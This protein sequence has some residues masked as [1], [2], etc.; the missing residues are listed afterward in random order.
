MRIKKNI[1]GISIVFLS[2]ILG[3]SISHGQEYN[4]NE[5]ELSL[6]DLL[7]IAS[8]SLGYF[9]LLIF[10]LFIYFIPSY[11]A[12]KKNHE[13]RWIIFVFNLIGGFTGILWLAAL[14]IAIFYDYNTNQSINKSYILDQHDSMLYNTDIENNLTIQQK[15]IQMLESLNQLKVIGGITEDEYNQQKTVIMNF[16]NKKSGIISVKDNSLISQKRFEE[17]IYSLIALILIIGV[18]ASSIIYIFY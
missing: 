11:I 18:F 15:K 1:F 3:I 16:T 6:F 12:F 7:P 8:F 13:H 9:L 17:K 5:V 2:T 10:I 14:F 4:N